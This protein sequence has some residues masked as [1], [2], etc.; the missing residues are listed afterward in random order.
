[1]KGI[2]FGLPFLFLSCKT[3]VMKISFLFLLILWASALNAQLT[4]FEK[5]NG[6]ETATFF[7]CIS[8]YKG[9]D[10][11]SSKISVKKIGMSDAGYPFDVVLFSN[12]GIFDPGAWHRNNKI[13]ILVNNGIHPGEPDGVDACM[14]LLRDLSANKIKLPDNVALAIIP[15]YNIGGALNR[16]SFSRVNQNGPESYGFRGNAQNLDLN[17]DFTKC[18]SRN[19]RSFAQIFHWLNP[20]IQVDNHVSD[21]ADYQH[22]MTLISTQW[23]KLG[24]E[25]GKFVHDVFDPSLYQ[26]MSKKGWAMCPYVNFEEG[27]PE[28]GWEAFYETP[29]YSS[30]YA[31]LFN[32]ISYIPETHMLKP[33][34]DRVMSTYALMQAIIEQSSIFA[35]KIIEKRKANINND[36]QKR[37]FALEWKPDMTKYDTILFKGY[38]TAYKTSEVTGFPRMYY[39]HSKPFEKE[40]KFYDYFSAEKFITVPKAYIIPQGWHDVIELLKLNKVQM[41]QLAKDSIIRVE[42]YHIDEYKSSARP[43]E[44][45]HKNSDVK[46]SLLSQSIHFLKG[47]YIIATDQPEKRFLVEMLEPTGDDS[48]FSWNFFDAVLQQKEGYSDY[49][50]E[51]VAAA[52]LKSNPDLRDKLEEKKKQDSLFAKNASAQLNFVYKNSPY[53]EPAHLRYPVFRLL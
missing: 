1:L 39:D 33:F 32:T 31:A 15:I 22:T 30:G 17:R 14:M 18:D 41:Q 26:S 27:N 28:K 52:Y 46:I 3:T 9:L 38:E 2:P 50:W 34:K 8:F 44:K 45:H 49:R 40:V 21:G 5:S 24:G 20:D 51:D 53:Y 29:R 13:V 6:K 47:D 4:P 16:N 48:Y 35:K 37:E 11:A 36:L 7:E 25:L 43:Y 12:D 19:A 42:A 10:K 23:N